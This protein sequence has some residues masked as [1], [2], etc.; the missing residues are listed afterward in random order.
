[1]QNESRKQIF[2][3]R[4]SN[5]LEKRNYLSQEFTPGSHEEFI[6]QRIITHSRVNRAIIHF[7]PNTNEQIKNKP[8]SSIRNMLEMETMIF[9][10][11]RD[12]AEGVEKFP[13]SSD[14][15]LLTNDQL[16][17]LQ[18]N[19]ALDQISKSESSSSTMLLIDLQFVRQT[20]LL[21]K[22]LDYFG[23]ERP[24]RLNTVWGDSKHQD[25]SE[26]ELGKVDHWLEKNIVDVSF[27]RL[28]DTL[29]PIA[30]EILDQSYV[31]E[32]S[33]ANMPLDS[34]NQNIHGKQH[35]SPYADLRHQVK[36]LSKRIKDVAKIIKE[37]SRLVPSDYEIDLMKY[38][39]LVSLYRNFTSYLLNLFTIKKIQE[40]TIERYGKKLTPEQFLTTTLEH[41]MLHQG[42]LQFF[43]MFNN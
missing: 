23:L 17:E 2:P 18:R 35:S 32:M 3:A 11:S 14:L 28:P 29:R 31:N 38:E 1:M 9:I 6:K 24:D 20:G 16:I 8:N 5:W 30:A 4:L 19:L 7:I 15:K 26:E 21:I 25:P 37:F 22:Y 10:K 36:N 43:E 12:E 34:R 39:I 13:K 41:I 27:D 33:F 40:S 42:S